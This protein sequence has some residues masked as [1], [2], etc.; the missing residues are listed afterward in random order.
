MCLCP[1]VFVCV[2]EEGVG[3]GV[4]LGGCGVPHRGLCGQGPSDCCQQS[5]ALPH[6]SHG[7]R[8]GVLTVIPS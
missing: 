7:S 1:C 2:G 3:G 4:G 5:T 8:S 6:G